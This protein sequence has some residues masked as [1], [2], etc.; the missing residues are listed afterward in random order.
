[1]DDRFTFLQ[2]HE[3]LQVAFRWEDSHLHE[4][5]TTSTP[6]NRKIWI[7]DPI[8]LEGVFGR[9]LLDEKDVQ[10]RE[11]L[12]NEKDKLV[13]VYDFGDDWE[14]DIVVE[15]ILPY[16][17]DGRYPYCVKATRMAP[18]ED[19][20]GEWLEHEAPQKPM[21]PKQLTDAVN[22][23]LEAFHADEHK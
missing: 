22:K 9:R 6:H 4:F 1:M 15:N 3:L 17:A 10:L 14:H 16:D 8:M 21:P 13:Y 18:E 23:D 19:S 11:F 20:G 2:F 7:G 5:H 12:Q